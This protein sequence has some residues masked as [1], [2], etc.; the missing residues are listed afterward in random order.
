MSYTILLSMCTIF[1]KEHVVFY[2]QY[3]FEV[4]VFEYIVISGLYIITAIYSI[5]INSSNIRWIKFNPLA[6]TNP[7]HLSEG[8]GI[9]LLH[10]TNIQYTLIINKWGGRCSWSVSYNVNFKVPS[11]NLH[12]FSPFQLFIQQTRLANDT[13]IVKS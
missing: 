9:N 6:D 2:L 5:S 8:G 4:T 3:F 10:D 11:A 12:A 1:L 13:V 7:K